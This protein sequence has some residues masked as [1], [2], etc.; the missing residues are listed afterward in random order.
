MRR[1]RR[2][3]LMASVDMRERW[4]RWRGCSEGWAPTVVLG[5]HY[6]GGEPV[7]S[8]PT[9]SRQATRGAMIPS[10]ASTQRS[11]HAPL[12]NEEELAAAE[13]GT[14]LR[15]S[16]VTVECCELR[17]LSAKLAG[18]AAMLGLRTRIDR[19]S[20]EGPVL[21]ERWNGGTNGRVAPRKRRGCAHGAQTSAPPKPCRGGFGTT[22]RVQPAGRSR[23]PT[24]APAGRSLRQK[25]KMPSNLPPPSPAPKLTR[26]CH[27]AHGMSEDLA[28][29]SRKRPALLTMR[30]LQ[31]CRRHAE[32]KL[33]ASS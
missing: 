21:V 1:R 18:G 3:L 4:V 30:R 26:R 32:Q 28:R 25:R 29:A 13:S 15:P 9:C 8:R 24:L 20:S 33:R 22:G 11:S 10:G 19:R 6:V 17:Y 5:V 23:R 31:A 12:G 7:Q 14:E 16:D 2:L 27:G